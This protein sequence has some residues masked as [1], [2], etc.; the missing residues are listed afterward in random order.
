MCTLE[1][2]FVNIGMNDIEEEERGDLPDLPKIEQPPNI[3]PIYSFSAQFSAVFNK[4]A[5]SVFRSF[6]TITSVAMPAIFMLLGTLVTGIA[7][8]NIPDGVN[9]VTW[10]MI[11]LSILAYFMIWAF[12]FNTSTY[13]GSIVL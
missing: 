3:N 12:I 10:N 5:I 13:C 8:R 7:F 2:A 11:K 1:D 4:K 6:S 9:E